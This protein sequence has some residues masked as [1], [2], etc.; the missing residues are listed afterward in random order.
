MDTAASPAPIF[1]K[2]A[3]VARRIGYDNPR[4]F[5]VNRD[6]LER[7]NDF[8][9]PM[10]TSMFPLKWRASEI[11]AWVARQGRPRDLDA[12]GENIVAFGPRRESAMLEKARA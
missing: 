12:A 8:P 5:L 4:T 3:A 11:D 7:E 6:R 2:A 10:P 1:I 9:L